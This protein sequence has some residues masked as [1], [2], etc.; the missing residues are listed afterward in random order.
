MRR[1]EAT[2]GEAETLLTTLAAMPLA[3]TGGTE[4]CRTTLIDLL[5][6]FPNFTNIVFFDRDGRPVCS[7]IES[8]DGL[9]APFPNWFADALRGRPF[10]VSMAETASDEEPSVIAT[11]PM[12]NEANDVVGV[13]TV[14]IRAARL[15]HAMRDVVLPEGGAI[16]LLDRYGRTLARRSNQ[17]SGDTW[18][19]P[20]PLGTEAGTRSSGVF[21]ATGRD[22]VE[23]RYVLMPLAG[24][25]FAVFG[26]PVA[27]I[28]DAAH[29]LLYSNAASALLMWLAALVTAALGVSRLVTRPLRRIR[30]GIIAYTD[31]DVH[32]RIRDIDDLPGEVQSLAD[33]FNR[34]ADAILTRDEALRDAVAQQ[35]ALTRE[36]H[37]R[38]RN[39]LQI[40]NSLMS[41]QKGRAETP[42]ETAI[43]S[44][45]QRRV[46]AL[47]LV[48]GAIYQGD[49][50]RSVK[51]APLLTELCAATEQSLREAGREPILVVQA[52]DLSASADIAVPLAFLVTEVIG[53]AV[54]HRDDH[55]PLDEM[56][57]IL[58]RADKGAA[59]IVEG[60]Q[61][62]FPELSENR[63]TRNG[64]NLLSG[65]VRQLG[66]MQTIDPDRTRITVSIPNL[67]GA[68]L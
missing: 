60:E 43:F 31:G 42:L 8:R 55:P 1:E 22:G 48:H 16:V 53:E 62:L 38:V 51:L 63:A 12:T 64:L 17:T 61:P 36:V 67:D 30:R 26:I 14:A 33:T 28:G 45:V 41:L 65:L 50:L 5:H 40:V 34:M 4:Q 13:L 47:G 39:N 49:D 2:I 15:E 21:D 20:N 44:E 25:A 19:P 18:L 56:R 37:H 24:D 27:T 32:A 52:E 29:F 3:R 23:R 58:R 10:S 66:G 9:P 54:F 68:G 6:T 46:T 35:K 57:I 59:L 7:G 11:M